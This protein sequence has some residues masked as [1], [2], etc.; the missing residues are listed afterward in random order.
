MSVK[1]IYRCGWFD[2]RLDYSNEP[3][4]PLPNRLGTSE[5]SGSQPTRSR[6][7]YNR[8]G[9]ARRRRVGNS[10]RNTNPSFSAPLALVFGLSPRITHFALFSLCV[11]VRIPH[12]NAQVDIRNPSLRRFPS[13]SARRSCGVQRAGR[14]YLANS[15][16]VSIQ[17]QMD[18]DVGR[19]V[20]TRCLAQ[21][22]V[23]HC[24][25]LRDG[26]DCG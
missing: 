5:C 22:C 19:P 1:A 3:R 10:R 4:H 20:E 23:N 9:C 18:L 6:H 8:S 15:L 21:Y 14:L 13:P 12:L 25:P 24:V 17:Q 26:V 16:L 7:C 11:C 2:G